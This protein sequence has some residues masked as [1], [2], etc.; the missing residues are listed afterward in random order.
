MSLPAV[1][2]HHQRS[3]SSTASPAAGAEL[4]A[5]TGST[6]SF[7]QLRGR[8]PDK[9]TSSSSSTAD[10]LHVP[11]A[12]TLQPSSVSSKAPSETGSS[13]ILLES[14]PN[15]RPSAAD[16]SASG[17]GNSIF[18]DDTVD[19]A[20]GPSGTQMFDPELTQKAVELL[21]GKIEK[22]KELIRE[23]QTSRDD[24]VN[25]YLKLSSNASN[26]QQQGRIKQVFEKK[27]QK[28]AQNIVHYQKK[29]EEYQK[30][31]QDLQE[32][33]VRPKQTHKLGMGLKNI[34]DMSNT[35]MSKPKEFAHLLRHKYKFGSADN[36]S[37]ISKDSDSDT[38]NHK[39]ESGNN[40]S[41]HGSASLPREN[42]AG[43]SGSSSR[44]VFD[45]NPK[46]KCISDDGRRSD[47]MSES[48]ATSASEAEQ[49]LS[50]PP[51]ASPS[52]ANQTNTINLTD[53]PLAQS[54]AQTIPHS[55]SAEW[56]T[57]MQEL[58]LHKEEV[59]HLREEM[60][61]LRQHFKQEL[62]TLMYQLREERDRYDRLEEQMND[63]TELHQ[64][65]IE[66]IKS[67][68]SDMEEKVQYQSEERLL[69]IKEHLQGL[70]TKVTSMEHQQA[71]QQYLNIEG[72]DSTD[73][74]AVM[75][76]L[77]TAIIT[78]V[79]VCLFIVG[80]VMNLARPFLSTSTRAAS[81]IMIV[82]VACVVYYRQE[83]ILAFYHKRFRQAESVETT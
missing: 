59:D 67:G 23:E 13:D 30:R 14:S 38:P 41:H 51:R 53:D 58:T 55:S 9:R 79:H 76:K 69:D 6:G 20:S 54:A 34:R 49:H 70:E 61:E 25:E 17:L 45:G 26:Q 56:S 83:S 80:T 36:L 8:S 18:Y 10:A 71:Q 27:N 81:T 57:I 75:M 7:K 48:A 65:E 21:Q 3:A 4:F 46:R 40:R 16:D 5:T 62:E 24:N 42:S 68:V 66:N 39:K 1:T 52:R 82:I 35:V 32:H 28:S 78:V 47:N 37:A 29:L 64:H 43:L 12:S 31:L 60:D 15:H 73:A 33:G 74:R 77:L 44:G 72:L 2:A 19:G 50:P 11:S 22:T 63:L